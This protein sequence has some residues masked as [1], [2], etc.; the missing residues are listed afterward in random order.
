M[1]VS[2]LLPKLRKKSTSQFNRLRLR[3]LRQEES[4]RQGWLN[5][6]ISTVVSKIVN[7]HPKT[8]LGMKITWL[9]LVILLMNPTSF[10][11]IVE[12]ANTRLQKDLLRSGSSQLEEKLNELWYVT[13]VH[14][15]LASNYLI[16]MAIKY[17]SHHIKKGS[18]T[19]KKR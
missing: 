6:T 12:Q 5:H 19:I 15:I 3:S 10:L 14:T 9:V 16:R 4:S 11:V 1:Q 17:S 7:S 8:K 13:L 2:R 18:K